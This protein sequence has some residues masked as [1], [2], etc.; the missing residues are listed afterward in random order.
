MRYIAVLAAVCIFSVLCY[1]Q[2]SGGKTP[3]KAAANTN[4]VAA[5]NAGGNSAA[6][7]TSL[8]TAAQPAAASQAQSPVVSDEAIRIAR[9]E[10]ERDANKDCLVSMWAAL[11]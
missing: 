5:N 4:A 11:G 2:P 3:A 9:A 8:P 7:Q 10:M 1:G 6:A